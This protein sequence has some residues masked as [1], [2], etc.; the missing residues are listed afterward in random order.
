[1]AN[2]LG[3]FILSSLLGGGQVRDY[4][5]AS[6]T[7][8]PSG[9]SRAGK[10]K[11]LFHVFFNINR[12]ARVQVSPRDLSYLV[13]KIDL[14]KFTFDI[15]TQNQYNRKQ[16]TNHKINYLPVNMSFHDDNG[17][18]IR[19]L[20]RT[21]YNYYVAD[22]RYTSSMYAFNDRYEPADNRFATRWGLDTGADEDFF[23]SIDIYSLHAGQSMKISLLKPIISAFSH[24]THDYSEGANLMEH[25]MTVQYSGVK[26]TNG[27]WSGTPGFADFQFYDTAPS[28]LAGEYAGYQVDERSGAI[29]NPGEQEYDNYEIQRSTALSK[30]EQINAA[31]NFDTVTNGNLTDTDVYNLITD[32]ERN[33]NGNTV[34]PTAYPE[35]EFT[36]GENIGAIDVGQ[37]IQAISEQVTL[38]DN[39]KYIGVYDQGTWQRQLEEKG[40]D[41]KSISIAEH[42]V[43]VAI[44]N[45]DVVDN[46]GAAR[47]AESFIDAPSSVTNQTEV[48]LTAVEENYPIS[49]TNQSVLTPNYNGSSWQQDLRS[50]GY[51]DSQI[52][53]VEDSLVNVKLGSSVDVVSYAEKY[54]Q[55][56][57]S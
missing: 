55:S 2:N 13:K 25:Q 33:A 41:P 9:F 27:Y 43:N 53:G 48:S 51:T 38:D 57:G 18:A 17:N 45:G 15:R 10:Y 37:N 46:S 28:D 21:Y 3:R 52:K 16:L 32:Q 14:P 22:G 8:R 23:V 24:D 39:K 40:Y 54:I 29:F 30:L 11:Y 36:S 50:K 1:M 47:L 7:F 20:W 19:E 4:A 34:F 56:S 42:S 31:D 35:N 5:H 6:K 12:A 49:F 44:N 26:Y